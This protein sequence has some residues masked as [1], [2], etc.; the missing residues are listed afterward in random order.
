MV[1]DNTMEATAELA[2]NARYDHLFAKSAT[3]GLKRKSAQG[4]FISMGSQGAKFAL[5]TGSMMA[6]ARLLSPEDFGLQSMVLALTGFFALFKDVGL[7]TVTVQREVITHRETSTLFWI[8]TLIGVVVAIVIA[9]MS[10]LVSGFY[11]EPR[12]RLMVLISASSF[13]LNGLSVQHAALLQRQFRFG[14]L[15]IIDLLSLVASAATGITMALLGYGYWS[16]V[17]AVIAEPIVTLVGSWLAMPWMPGPPSR[18]PGLRAMLKFGGILTANSLVVFLAYNIEKILLGRLWGAEMLGLYGRGYQLAR[19][20][21]DQVTAGI[22]GVALASLSRVQS[23]P[24]RLCNA[25]LKIYSVVISLTVPIT[26]CCAVL[27]GEIT[28]LVLGPGWTEAGIVLRLLTP[29]ILVLSLIN[30]LS[31]LMI[32]SGHARRSLNIAFLIAP[33]MTLGVVLAVPFGP[34]GVAIAFSSVLALLAIPVIA[35]AKAGTAIKAVHIWNAVKAPLISGVP[36]IASGLLYVTAVT[37]RLNWFVVLVSATALIFAVY[38]LVMIFA[39]RQRAFWHDL[40][41]QI[42]KIKT[43]NTDTESTR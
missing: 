25:F 11:H 37:G 31:W 22:T 20:P 27:S 16:L 12:L 33:M 18:C 14:A 24:Q 3:V 38:A 32:S 4:A 34:R 8:N 41:A 35:W 26:V 21:S 39:F 30:P 15:A 17:G 5:R 6:L 2:A 29:S 40:A 36:A 23:D 28:R 13:I 42:L 19:L 43:P 1:T 9:S 10:T 7:S